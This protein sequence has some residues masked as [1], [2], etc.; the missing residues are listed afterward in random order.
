MRR[1]LVL[2]FNLLLAANGMFMLAAPETWYALVPGI[3]ETGPCNAHFIRDVG[4]AYLVAGAALVW[5]DQAKRARPAALAGAA[6]L[7]LHALIH[8]W[9]VAAG[10]EAPLQFALDI[11]LVILP[12]LLVF[13]L[14]ALIQTEE[15]CAE[16]A[17]AATDRCL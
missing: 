17:D 6:F 4:A 5:F 10:R 11:P 12:G 8:I 7:T 9:D 2:L 1:Y 14:A 13:R 16:M 3:A 15:R